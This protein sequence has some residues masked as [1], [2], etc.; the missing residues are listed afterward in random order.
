MNRARKIAFV[1]NGPQLN[2][3]QIKI[4]N[5]RLIDLVIRIESTRAILMPRFSF[6]LTNSTIHYRMFLYLET[7]FLRV[8]VSLLCRLQVVSKINVPIYPYQ[9]NEG[10][11]N[12]L[13]L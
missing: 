6:F 11:R 7:C 1:H 12:C 13:S 9:I 3:V 8:T 10:R 5:G 2:T 4:N